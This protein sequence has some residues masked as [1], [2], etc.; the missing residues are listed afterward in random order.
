MIGYDLGARAPAEYLHRGQR[1]Q[2]R[3]ARCS[4]EVRNTTR[5]ILSH[6]YP[7]L[8]PKEAMF[9]DILF[10]SLGS[11]VEEIFWEHIDLA[12]KSGRYSGILSDRMK[13]RNRCPAR[14]D[15]F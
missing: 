8:R 12:M 1:S 9:I 3:M 6:N 2:S 13:A 11:V 7:I 5:R 10:P 4:R 14:T 15:F